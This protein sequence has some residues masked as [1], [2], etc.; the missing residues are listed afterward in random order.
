MTDHIPTSDAY[1]PLQLAFDHFNTELF[2]D[3]L[4]KRIA[5]VLFTYQR[6]KNTAGYLSSN[7]FGNRAGELVHELA[8]NPEYFAVVPL[9]EVLQT[10][11]HEMV[12]AY[13]ALHGG[14]GRAN[15]HNRHFAGLMKQIGLMPSETGRP[16][17]AEVGQRMAEY[18]IPGGPFEMAVRKLM[19]D[20]FALI[21][22]D[23]F[24]PASAARPGV[25]FHG[26][27]PATMA[28]DPS[29]EQAVEVPYR[30]APALADAVQALPPANKN[31]SN[32]HKY[33]CAP[34]RVS[35]WGRPGLKLI[36]GECQRPF[37][38]QTGDPT[39]TPAVAVD[40]DEGAGEELPTS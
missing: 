11:A 38:E 4:G 10:V 32:R 21:W 20:D 13:Q 22:Y 28:L 25:T 19:A 24:V 29:L 2:Q 39:A 27:I 14:A 37:A 1:G 26:E 31:K 5:P 17:G 8:V 9:T 6:Q 18:V 33:R 40:E 30:V 3:V 15:Y 23:R 12:H 34:C 16:G 7:R 35:V 36:C